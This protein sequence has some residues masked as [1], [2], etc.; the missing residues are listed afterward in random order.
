MGSAA[1][2][3]FRRL[4]VVTERL[5]IR[6]A[7]VAVCAADG[8]TP[9]ESNPDVVMVDAAQGCDT[10]RHWHARGA[11]VVVIGH[12]GGRPSIPDLLQAGAHAVVL[13]TSPSSDLLRALHYASGGL[14]M[15]ATDVNGAG[16]WRA[17]ALAGLS[18][19]ERQVFHGLVEGKRSKEVAFE[20]GLSPKTVDS[21]RASMMAK[22]GIHEVAGLVRYGVR[23]KLI[24]DI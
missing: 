4:A 23:H 3:R 6:D 9:V 5:L 18:P 1:A 21:Y 15:P 24:E 17:D 19:R 12:P 14:R 7:L 16:E 8:W 20:L 13:E 22:L 11:A 10:V 2:T